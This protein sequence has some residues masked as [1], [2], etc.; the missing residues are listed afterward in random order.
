MLNTSF[1]HAGANL[2]GRRRSSVPL[3]PTITSYTEAVFGDPDIARGLLNSAVIAI[4]TTLLTLADR[5]ARGVRPGPAADPV[6]RRSLLMLF[7]VVQMVPAVNLA[8]PMFVIFSN[9]RA[10]RHLRSA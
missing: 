6:R 10:G 8:L 4:G 2:R 5:R 1:K 7:L 3:P 9:A